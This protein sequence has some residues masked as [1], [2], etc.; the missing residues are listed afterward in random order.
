MS[1]TIMPGPGEKYTVRRQVFK[2]FGAGF[3]I[4]GP[5]GG[6]VAYCKQKA[7]RLKEDLRVYTDE[8][9]STLL[10]RI[11]ARSI[12]DFSAT[13]DIFSPTDEKIGSL[14]RKGLTSTFF[15]DSWLVFD[16]R[17][18]QVGTLREDSG[19]L[20]ILRRMNDLIA[21]LVPQ[22]FVLARG[23]DAATGTPVAT[24]RTH[25]N[26]FIYRLGVTVHQDDPEF[27]DLFLLGVCCL[28]AAIEG[29]QN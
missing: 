2:L 20:A 13:Y 14:R 10:L 18:V 26:P 3:H 21:A 4:Y 19:A 16:E 27:H 22:K 7:F 29:R 1:K 8:S 25:I 15:R 6:L 23:M 24:F 11:A 28:I 5:D 17:E 12:I 9:Q